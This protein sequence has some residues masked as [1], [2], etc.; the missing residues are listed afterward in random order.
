M[1]NYITTPLKQYECTRTRSDS[2]G[3]PR[4]VVH[5]LSLGLTEYPN[6]TPKT[7][8]QLGL[9]KYRGKDFGGGYVFQSYSVENDLDWYYITLNPQTI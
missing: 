2:N 1:R 3:N 7:I 9:T 6:K 8:S 4:Y 5:F